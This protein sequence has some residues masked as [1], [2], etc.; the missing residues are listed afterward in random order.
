M[1]PTLTVDTD[2]EPGSW[3]RAI[4]RGCGPQATDTACATCGDRLC[5]C[6]DT[7]WAA[8]SVHNGQPLAERGQ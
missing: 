2:S 5:G 3:E 6:T 1:S 8:R 7:Q 4:A